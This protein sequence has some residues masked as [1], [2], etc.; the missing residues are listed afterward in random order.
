MSATTLVKRL[1]GLLTTALLLTMAASQSE[2]AVSVEADVDTSAVLIG[3]VITYRITVTHGREDTVETPP[4]GINLFSFTVRDYQRL[5]PRERED[6]TI[7]SGAVYRIAA[8]RPGTY[9]I[10][11]MPLSYRLAG[12]QTGELVTQPLTI[13]VRSLG[14][15]EE[16]TLRDIHGPMVVPLQVR[17]WV[18]VVVASLAAVVLGVLLYLLWRSKRRRADEEGSSEPI[19]VD[20]IA[21]FDK[22][23]AAALIAEGRI[24]ELYTLVSEAIRRYVGRRFRLDAMEMTHDELTLAFSDGHVSEAESGVILTFL[25]RCELVKFAKFVPGEEEV[26][27]LIERAKDV[28]RQTQIASEQED[29]VIEVDARA[30]GPASEAGDGQ[31]A[32]AEVVEAELP[33]PEA[34]DGHRKEADA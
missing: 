3:D 22:I 8:Y 28:V 27:S 12:G 18:W 30:G 4:A 23:P 14:V 16:D 13:E 33:A 15:G 29:E 19:V 24:G 1:T 6:G 17:T 10:P 7:V 20:E 32:P 34:A 2:A 9:V 25:A 26:S 5:H 21:E 11:P 31:E